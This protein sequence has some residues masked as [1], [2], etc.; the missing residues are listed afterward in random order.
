MTVRLARGQV[1]VLDAE[2][3]IVS[4]RHGA[5]VDLSALL[6]TADGVVRAD[7]DLVFYN[8]P[9][10][11]G[12]RL[13]PGEAG[14]PCALVLDLRAIPAGIDHVRI[15]VALDD[16]QDSLG[17]Y[18]GPELRIDDAAGN[19]LGEY[20]IDGLGEES[21]VVAMDLDRA[22]TEWLLRPLGHGY[23]SGFA[24]LVAAHGVAVGRTPKP[25]APN[26][27]PEPFDASLLDMSRELALR[28]RDGAELTHVKMA[29]GWDPVRE[30]GRFGLREADIDLDASALVFA[31]RELVDAAFY[32]QLSSK[33]GSVRHQGDNLTGAGTGDNEMIDV[34]LTLL[35]EEASTVVFVVTSYAGHT[36]ERVRNAF[37]R[38]VDGSTNVELTGGN[39]RVGGK[40]TGMV[41]AKVQREA[42]VWKFHTVGAPIQAGH[43]VEAAEQVAPYL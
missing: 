17:A 18:P 13:M 43:P 26:Q 3:I 2:H 29:L 27:P 11:E 21:T 36:F 4:V 8:Q 34:D 9:L 42:D 33:D 20:V 24:A 35:A 5:A 12:V 40:H 16:Q 41:V 28:K 39:L 7:A 10:G 19:C 32:G 22:G 6:L 15:V 37:W 25:P 14:A 31:G 23:H 1:N 30:P 38:L